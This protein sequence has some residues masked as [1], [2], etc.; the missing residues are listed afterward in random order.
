MSLLR[1]WTLIVV[2]SLRSMEV[3]K[4]LEFHQNILICVPKMNEGLPG[5]EQHE[6]AQLMT[7]FTF[8]GA[9]SL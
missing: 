8:L 4:A 2:V 3:Q 5:S 6:G 1:F 9:L 7:E